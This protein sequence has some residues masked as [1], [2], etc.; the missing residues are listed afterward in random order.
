VR[1]P[2]EFQDLS[3][4]LTVTPEAVRKAF[5]DVNP[6]LS[7]DMIQVVCSRNLLRELRICFTKDFAP[8]SCSQNEQN[9]RLCAY[10]TVTM[11]PVRGGGTGP[12]G[13]PSFWRRD[14]L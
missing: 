10:N 13:F 1:I 14:S 11:P 8:R 12:H 4:P 5:V 9:R 6:Q 2:E 3:K 7:S